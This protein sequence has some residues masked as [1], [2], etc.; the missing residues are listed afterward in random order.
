MREK[1]NKNTDF[2]ILYCNFQNC[3]T[4]SMYQCKYCE[5]YYCFKHSNIVNKELSVCSDCITENNIRN[6]YNALKKFHQKN[7]N[8]RNKV[9]KFFS[10][11]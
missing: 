3:F 11:N 8:F 5:N 1:T 10:I 7:N 9:M 2:D 6:I 4:N